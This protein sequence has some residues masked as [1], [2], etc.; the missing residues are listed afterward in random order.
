MT[1]PN[2]YEDKELQGELDQLW[3]WAKAGKDQTNYLMAIENVDRFTDDLMQL[4]TQKQL[5][6]REDQIKSDFQLVVNNGYDPDDVIET[7]RSHQLRELKK[8]LHK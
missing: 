6:A 1:Q 8:G 7:W 5:E 3:G 2:Q 4:I